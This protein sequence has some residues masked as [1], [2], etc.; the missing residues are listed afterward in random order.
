MRSR[1]RV[2]GPENALCL[3]GG[4]TIGWEI[5]EQAGRSGV[6]LDRVFVQVGG[7]ALAACRGAGLG[8]GASA[9]V[10]PVPLHAVQAEGCAP[11]AGRGQRASALGRRPRPGH[12]SDV[13]RPWEPDPH[14]IADGIL[15][16]E[17]YDWIG[18]ID[19]MRRNG[20]S[21]VVAPEADDRTCARDLAT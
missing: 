16:D 18:V 6:R 11:L 3:D 8:D 10:A 13:M 4:R 1:S 14:S 19:A 15:D 12:W 20:G 7:G 17:T 2:Q 9:A 21:P 5:A